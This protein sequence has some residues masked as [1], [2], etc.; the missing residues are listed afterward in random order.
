MGEKRQAKIQTE[1]QQT[2]TES[3]SLPKSDPDQ[4][5]R[6]ETA[7]PLSELKTQLESAQKEAG[8][9]YD[10]LLRVS[11]D[12]ENYKK[13]S[14]REMED[15]RKFA[16][17]SLIKAL[18]PV[19]DNLERALDSAGNNQHVNDAFVEGVQLT[20]SEVLKIFEK[21]NVNPIESLEKPFDPGFH[22]AVMQQETDNYPDK[23]VLTELQKGYL[24]HAKL[25]RPA[26][27]VVSKKKEMPENQ[28]NDERLEITKKEMII[29]D[30]EEDTANG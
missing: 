29:S 1:N 12:F 27:V 8:E 20:L 4:G 16:N 5:V 10:R 24:M 13:R 15:F 30:S 28:E 6:A 17:E 23:T 18:L 25:I 3:E 2:D 22:Q 19:I 21:F 11:A 26:M 9:N 7:D 14:A